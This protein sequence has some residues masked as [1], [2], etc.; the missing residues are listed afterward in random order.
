MRQRVNIARAL[1]ADPDV[2]LLD[3]PF[4]GLDAQTREIMQ[5]ELL[6]IWDERK[7][8]AIFVTH[9]IDEAVYLADRVVAFST[10]PARIVQEWEIAFDRPRSLDIKQT[11]E[12]RR[13]ENEIWQVL[14][15]EATR[16]P[17]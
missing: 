6:K 7:K 12:H 3:E 8:T 4:S 2:L 1:A 13:L 9:Q 16:G 11:P 5:A 15:R 17:I 14:R 10:C